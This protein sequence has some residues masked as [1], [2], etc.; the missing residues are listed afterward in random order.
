MILTKSDI[1]RIN[2]QFEIQSKINSEKL[3]EILLIV[4]TNR[5]VR[6]LTKELISVSKSKTSGKINIETLSTFSE[7][8]LKFHKNFI[9]LSEAVSTVLINRTARD[10]KKSLKYFKLYHDGIPNG[11]LERI[12]NLISELKREGLSPVNII[13]DL[14]DLTLSDKNKAE[15]LSLIYSEF[16]KKCNDFNALE[17]GDIYREILDLEDKLFLQSFN[18]YYAKANLVIVNGF[19]EFTLPEVELV[20]RI[21]QIIQNL[22][23]NFD[24]YDNNEAIFSHLDSCYNKLVKKGFRKIIEIQESEDSNF[25]KIIRTK[26]FNN[27]DEIS[28][29]VFKNS[30]TKLNAKNKSKEIEITAKQIKKLITNDQVEPHKICVAF[31]LIRNYST[32]VRDIFTAYGIPFNLT[33]R[34]SLQNSL[35]IIELVNFLEILENDFYYKNILKTAG[36]RFLNIS[37]KIDFSNL[38]ITASELK[39]VVGKNIWKES[40]KRSLEA[41]KIETDDEDNFFEDKK[42]KEKQYKKVLDDIEF[43]EESLN[44]FKKELSPA[45]FK[46][47][48][49]KLIKE[50]EIP[51]LVLNGSEHEE[52][53]IKSLSTFVE[54]INEMFDLMEDEYGKEKKFKLKFYLEEIRTASTWARFNVK[55]RPNYG[56]QI[57]SINEIRGLN[58]DYLFISGMF[59]GEFPTRFQPEIFNSLKFSSKEAKHIIEQRYHFY[60]ALCTW[61]KELYLTFPLLDSKKELVESSFL[62]EFSDLFECKIKDEDDFKNLVYSKEEFLIN[63]DNIKDDKFSDNLITKKSKAEIDESIKI[64]K[65]RFDQDESIFN[66]III[67]DENL[68]I[69]KEISE[70]LEK[71]KLK[72]FSISQLETYAKCPFK[73]YVEKLL[74]IQT[75]QEPDEEIEATEL[76]SL[77][78][79]IFFHFYTEIRDK[80][81]SLINCSDLVFNEAHEILNEIAEKLCNKY[82]KDIPQN[83]YEREKIFGLDGKKEDSILYRFLEEERKES[84]DEPK[85]FEVKFGY[86]SNT[87]TDKTL[88]KD[89][90]IKYKDISLRGKIDRIDVNE[91]NNTFSIVDYKLSKYSGTG[92]DLAEG[93]ALQLPVYFYA[94]KE[95]LSEKMTEAKPLKAIIFSLKI[96]AEKFGKKEINITGSRKRN[97]S[98]TE[99]IELNENQIEASLEM[100]NKYISNIGIGKFPLTDIRDYETK[101]CKYCDFKSACRIS[102]VK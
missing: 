91:N 96:D 75:I 26:L 16:L 97:I 11:T 28:I 60:Q 66:G 25:V 55:E 20:N 50:L 98:E 64:D 5:K 9:P 58:Y 99:K 70:K 48:L 90:P 22:F 13:N 40:I 24:Y 39:I 72:E 76:G 15:D 38:L 45:E 14:Q 77:L 89:E 87:G 82:L 52:V 68:A 81:I 94:A 65:I 57:T 86:L 61:R 71:I 92:N 27:T 8:I 34:I 35:P 59:D 80:G 85:Y 88:S 78:H 42:K 69:H 7:N 101:V 41:L 84:D 37:K 3:D 17:V 67:T 53:N 73:Y 36:S 43:I 31:N 32:Y 95:L 21:A 51:L 56:V 102:E 10:L 93:I 47:A 6:S 44:P 46:D 49:F 79:D 1:E 19:D 23:I 33:D 62:K 2:I 100:V 18:N 63:L 30:I 4:P 12:K 54:T 29:D 83:F 74:R